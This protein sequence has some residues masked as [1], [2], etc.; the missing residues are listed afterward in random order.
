V[1]ASAT[2]TATTAG[3]ISLEELNPKPEAQES[4]ET[5]SLLG[6]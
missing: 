3:Q 4:P 2:T 5:L 6:E 1:A